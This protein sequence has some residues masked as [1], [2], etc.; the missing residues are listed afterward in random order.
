MD[1]FLR[2]AVATSYLPNPFFTRAYDSRLLYILDGEGELRLPDKVFPL[3]S[4]TLCYYPSGQPY[5][6]HSSEDK[7]LY[8]VTINFDFTREYSHFSHVTPTLAA[9][10]FVQESSMPSHLNQPYEMFKRYF[11]IPELHRFRED[12]LAVANLSTTRLPHH[13]EAAAARLA[14]ILYALLDCADTKQTTSVSL[15]IEYIEK[16]LSDISSNEDVS[17]AL[18]YHPNH[19][20][21]LF[22]Q[23]LGTT[24]HRYITETKVK[25]AAELLM[26]SDMSISEVSYAVGF[27]NSNHFSSVFT[28]IYGIPPTKFRRSTKYI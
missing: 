23:Q 26:N 15:A 7:P 5:W 14:S 3:K 11:V 1:I 24:V 21:R 4:G 27:K 19:L 20:N 9:E 2:Y 22:K 8:F 6:P 25:K 13:R 28:K 10:K 16:N 18:H 12:F 17:R